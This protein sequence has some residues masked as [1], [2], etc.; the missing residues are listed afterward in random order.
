MA[1]DVLAVAGAETEATEQMDDFGVQAADF[2]FLDGLFAVF[3]DVLLHLGLGFD[4][5]F[6]DPR[7]VNTAISDELAQSHTGDLAAHRVEAADDDDAGRVVD[8]HVDAGGFF[9]GADVSTFAANDATFHFVVGNVDRAG[10]RFRGVAGCVA[11]DGGDDNFARFGFG[12]FVHVALVALI[13]RA[14]LVLQLVI[15]HFQQATRGFL[16]GR[17]PLS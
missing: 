5:D 2:G 14:L 6:L 13:N 3:L 9:E 17:G 15:E 16:R 11:L 10:G 8:D 4:D 7:G 1:E 12:D